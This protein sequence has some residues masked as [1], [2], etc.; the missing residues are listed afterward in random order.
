[1][2]VKFKIKKKKVQNKETEKSI[3]FQICTQ[4]EILN[5]VKYQDTQ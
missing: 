1:M 5:K 3:G 2:K 4:N